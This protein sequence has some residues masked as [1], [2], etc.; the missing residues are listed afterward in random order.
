VHGNYPQYVLKK[1]AAAREAEVIEKLKAHG[2]T[3]KQIKELIFDN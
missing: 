3:D 1:G 2:M